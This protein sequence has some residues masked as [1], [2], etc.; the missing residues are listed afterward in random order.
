MTNPYR[1]FVPLRLKAQFFAPSIRHLKYGIVGDLAAVR[2]E[3]TPNFGAA[4]HCL[5]L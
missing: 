2:M 1:F 5:S 4:K 3:Y